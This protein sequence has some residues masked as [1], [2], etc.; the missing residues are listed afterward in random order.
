MSNC[1][2]NILKYLKFVEQNISKQTITMKT[3]LRFW[4]TFLIMAVSAGC[5]KPDP[6]EADQKAETLAGYW[7]VT[8]IKDYDYSYIPGTNGTETDIRIVYEFDSDIVANDGNE[9]YAV[10]QFTGSTMALIATDCPDQAELIDITIPYSYEDGKIKSM[11]FYD[12]ET[13]LEYVTVTQL[14]STSLVLLMDEVY[15][16]SNGTWC[17]DTRHITLK[18]IH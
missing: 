10:I 18:K 16:E 7:E 12:P 9:E 17:H 4:A 11:F 5:F 3:L 14:T 8:H 6:A 15:A 13:N 2:A 1:I